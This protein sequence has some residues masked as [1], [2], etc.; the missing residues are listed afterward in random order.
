MKNLFVLLFFGLLVFFFNPVS[1]QN[2]KVGLKGGYNAA[3]WEG[4]AMNNFQSI[5]QLSDG[6][7]TTE[8]RSGFHAGAY[9]SIPVTSFLTLEPGAFYSQK[10][11]R[12]SGKL[13]SEK[14]DFLNLQATLTNKA[15]YVDVPLLAKVFVADGFHIYGGP[16]VSFL[17]SNKI[18]ARAGVLGVN[19]INH[20]INFDSQI[21]KT[22][23]GLVGGIGY[24]FTNG[25]NLSGGY[26][27]GLNT[28]DK[29][30]HLKTFNRVAKISMGFEF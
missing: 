7:A 1:A 13:S 30:G 26:D 8:M 4:N 6:H 25:F 12:L 18:N 24:R 11:M 16:Q 19:V 21:R 17:A 9:L 14:L 3:N 28:V 15:E 27:Y 29:G 5:V 10:G 23:V 20:D 2:I 22:D